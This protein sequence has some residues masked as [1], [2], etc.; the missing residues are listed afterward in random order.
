VEAWPRLRGEHLPQQRA[1]CVAVGRWGTYAAVQQ[2]GRLVRQRAA[3][4]LPGHDAR[5]WGQV[6]APKVGYLSRTAS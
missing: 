3:P 6:R 5:G 1:E 4:Q 2:L